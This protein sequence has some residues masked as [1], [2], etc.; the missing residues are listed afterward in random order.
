MHKKVW[1]VVQAARL[2][3]GFSTVASPLKQDKWQDKNFFRKI[4]K[5][6]CIFI[7]NVV[8]YLYEL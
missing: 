4:R 5:R 7:D 1:I 3:K 8:E 2:K 6:Y